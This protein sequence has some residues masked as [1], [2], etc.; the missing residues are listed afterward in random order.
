MD[1]GRQ[2]SVRATGPTRREK[3]TSNGWSLRGVPRD[4]LDARR[5]SGRLLVAARNVRSSTR[6]GFGDCNTRTL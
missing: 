4:Q 6:S 5:A 2:A 3:C 1:E